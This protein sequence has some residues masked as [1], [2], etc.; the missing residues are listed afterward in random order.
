MLFRSG[1]YVSIAVDSSNLPSFAYF[2]ADNGVPTLTDYTTF[3]VGVTSSIDINYTGATGYFTSIAL[4]SSDW[5]YVA[6]YDDGLTAGEVQM[7]VPLEP[8]FSEVV[9][10]DPGWYVSLA[11]RSDD[12]PCA[13]WQAV[14]DAD[15]RYG[16]RDASDNWSIETVDSTGAVG[17]E[18]AL[19]FDASDN[20][21]IAYYD[22]SNG[23]LKVATAK[24]G[25]WTILTVDSVGDVGLAPSIVVSG[26]YV[27]ISYYDADK[28]VL[29]Y[30]VGR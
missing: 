23:D 21:W 2:D 20:P 14:T 12:V 10:E 19:A 8:T 3:G 30:A 22:E 18:A 13:A 9:D 17:V 6:Y 7:A 11:M 16:C 24:S 29:K 4:D 26:G 1:S 25:T 5:D 28:G 15:L 27:Y